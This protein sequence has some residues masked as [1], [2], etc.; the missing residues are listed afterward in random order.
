M[1]QMRNAGLLDSETVS[2][3]AISQKSGPSKLYNN[4]RFSENKMNGLI[5]I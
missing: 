5:I 2:K 1:E 4:G 3:M